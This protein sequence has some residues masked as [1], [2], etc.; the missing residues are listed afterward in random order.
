MIPN[1]RVYFSDNALWI[2]TI[3]DA[4]VAGTLKAVMAADG[5]TVNIVPLFGDPFIL[6][7]TPW[8]S[9]ADINGNTFSTSAAVMTYLAAQLVMRRQISEVAGPA[10][11]AAVDLAQ[12][13]PVTVSRA[14][15]QLLPA[16]ADT[17]ALAFVTGLAG[18]DTA[19]GFTCQPQ[20]GNVTLTDWTDIAGQPTLFSGVPYFLAA[21]GGLTVSPFA[22]VGSCITRV[23][24]AASPT[25]LAVQP[26]DPITL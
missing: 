11:V 22:P 26:S 2:D 12:G 18:S 4:F 1:V 9:I 19:Q 10:T 23:G 8:T 17:Y 5:V 6:V 14:N 21:T 3:P 15:G 13:L 7:A 25:T 20:V 24:I 16:R